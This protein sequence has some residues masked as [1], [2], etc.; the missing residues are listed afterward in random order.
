MLIYDFPMNPSLIRSGVDSAILN[1]LSGFSLLESQIKVIVLG[2]GVNND[3]FQLYPNVKVVFNRP[4]IQILTRIKFLDI[5]INRRYQIKRSIIKYNPDIIHL[6]T[7]GP[8][9]LSL[10][11]LSK[12]NIVVTQ[13]GIMKQ[14]FKEQITFYAKLKFL[15]KL[16]VEKFYFPRFENIIFISHY[17]KKLFNKKKIQKKNYSIIPN[18]ISTDF[19][20]KPINN[21]KLSCNLAYVGVVNRRK[22]LLLLLKCINNL[23]HKGIN[24][25]L[26]IAGGSKENEY[27][28]KVQEYIKIMNLETNVEYYGWTSKENVRR[29][30]SN[31]D[32]LILPSNQE[33][34]PV[35][36]IESLALAT[37]VIATSVGGIPEMIVNDKNGFLFDKGSKEQLFEI[38]LKI[39]S[40]KSRIDYAKMS[41]S[42]NNYAKDNYHPQIIS[43][44]TLL[45]YKK[46]CKKK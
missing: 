25:R 2:Q 37:P 5:L 34:L 3:T 44:K 8:Y 1:L 10:I 26:H 19:F 17:N 7:T 15:F 13:H 11:G 6:Q 14:E 39:Y 45:F 12:K 27:Q 18:P 30:I 36:I 42:A 40:P 23:I 41:I 24:L 20:S 28:K 9:L 31:S 35:V 46:I 21:S 32:F 22:N 4:Y 16:M 33:T 38:L 29:L 43:S